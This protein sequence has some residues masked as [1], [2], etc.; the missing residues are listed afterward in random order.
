MFDLGLRRTAMEANRR[1]VSGY[2]AQ[3]HLRD[4]ASYRGFDPLL[5]SLSLVLAFALHAS[6]FRQAS[7]VTTIRWTIA[8][9]PH[10]II[11]A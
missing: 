8:R 3:V 6:S 1:L 2:G 4:A 10:L 11:S 7:R 5:L 9:S